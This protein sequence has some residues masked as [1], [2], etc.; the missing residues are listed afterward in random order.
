MDHI[1][2]FTAYSVTAFILVK[3]K[4]GNI[5]SMRPL[6]PTF[7]TVCASAAGGTQAAV[8]VDLVLAGGAGRTGR[9]LAL[10]YV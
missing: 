5:E 3:A 7:L 1:T 10:V 6:M 8:A 2:V 9:R 4:E